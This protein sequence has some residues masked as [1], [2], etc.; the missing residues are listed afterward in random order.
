MGTNV[1]TKDLKKPVDPHTNLPS[2][3][4]VANSFGFPAGDDRKT[5]TAVGPEKRNPY[6]DPV[7]GDI[8]VVLDPNA[9]TTAAKLEAEE[10]RFGGP[11]LGTRPAVV[12]GVD[13]YRAVSIAKSAM[14]VVDPNTDVKLEV[15]K[16]RT[17]IRVSN[18]TVISTDLLL[19]YITT[20]TEEQMRIFDDAMYSFFKLPSPA[21]PITI[22]HCDNKQISNIIRIMLEMG[23]T[24]SDIEQLK[25][26]KG[27]FAE[28]SKLDQ[29]L[30][31]EI[32]SAII[33]KR[34]GEVNMINAKIDSILEI[35]ND[36]EFGKEKTPIVDVKS[37]VVTRNVKPKAKRQASVF[38]TMTEEQRKQHEQ[39]IIDYWKSDMNLSRV[40]RKFACSPTTVKK[41]L[42]KHGIIEVN[43]TK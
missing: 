32:I 29:V 25:S 28:D 36:D 1:S 38:Y 14:K 2:L 4:E 31:S 5:V 40:G 41:I 21:A 13:S 3:Q 15:G 10:A 27:I 24:L 42:K 11:L 33:E 19:Q 8:F 30:K 6:T 20:L 18:V 17:V 16:L 35:L 37:G 12:L 34:T 26:G 23:S 43:E 39:N 22:D 9:P 7:R